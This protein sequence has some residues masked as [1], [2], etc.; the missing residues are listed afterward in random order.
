MKETESEFRQW[1]KK[2]N[3]EEEEDWF[4]VANGLKIEWKLT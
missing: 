1:I 4:D 2:T 3:E